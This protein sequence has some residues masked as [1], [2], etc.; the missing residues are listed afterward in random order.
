[1]IK[2]GYKPED[3]NVKANL[4]KRGIKKGYKAKKSAFKKRVD[5]EG[6]HEYR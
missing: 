3:E 5:D 4:G 6:D 2:K 1:M